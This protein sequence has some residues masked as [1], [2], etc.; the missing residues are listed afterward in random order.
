MLMK[1]KALESG[2]RRLGEDADALATYEKAVAYFAEKRAILERLNQINRELRKLHK[3]DADIVAVALDDVPFRN[4]P[5][6]RK[7]GRS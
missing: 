2:R 5:G 7:V 3:L 1:Y 6:R 4:A